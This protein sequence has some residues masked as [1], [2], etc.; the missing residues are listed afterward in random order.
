M[1][2]LVRIAF[3]LPVVD[4]LI[5]VAEIHIEPRGTGLVDPN[6]ESVLVE[7]GTGSF[8]AVM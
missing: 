4:R 1:V 5:L 3:T 8:A 7:S 2:D 6:K